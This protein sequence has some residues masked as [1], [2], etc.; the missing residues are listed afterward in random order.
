MCECF[1]AILECELLA[2][3]SFPNAR[4]AAPKVFDLQHLAR[5]IRTPVE[6]SR[7]MSK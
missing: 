6:S 4:A 2:K 5:G 7:V 3:H 1:N